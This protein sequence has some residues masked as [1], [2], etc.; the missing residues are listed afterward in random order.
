MIIRRVCILGGS[1]FVGRALANQLASAGYTMSIPT[2]Y[3]EKCRGDLILLPGVDLVEANVHDPVQLAEVVRGCDA[4]INLIGILNERGRKG[5]GFELVHVS[6]AEKIVAVC[7]QEGIQRVLQMSALNADADNG[8]SYYLRS[9]GK[10]EQLLHAESAL[11]VTSFR[12]S[13]IFGESDSFFNR[14]AGLLKISPVFFPLAC[15]QARFAPVYV[16]DVARAMTSTLAD[17]GS[18]GQQYELCGPE[19]YTLKQLLEF[20][21]K[22]LHLKRMIIPLNDFL[23]RLQAA[24]FDF[25]PGKPFST[26]NYLS[27]RKPSVCTSCDWK[28]F[29]IEPVAIETRVPEYL[30]KRN[31]RSCYDDYR[32]QL[33]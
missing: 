19:E 29:R 22:C 4:V 16:G 9:K 8:E 1:G 10:A 7:K 14:F 11:Q 24:V 28:Q 6:L 21:A 32:K 27:A 18:I 20:T 23:S 5:S 12:P 30:A 31:Y 26:D 25:V 2:R 13:V 3:R 15:H 33:N 17:P